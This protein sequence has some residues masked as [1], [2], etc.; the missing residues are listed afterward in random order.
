MVGDGLIY[1]FGGDFDA[2]IVLWLK[3]VLELCGKFV[4]N[5]CDE[6]VV[7]WGHGLRDLV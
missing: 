2:Y 1:E 5:A 3:A 4:V 6:Q 7:F